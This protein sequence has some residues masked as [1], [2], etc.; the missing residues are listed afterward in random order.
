MLRCNFSGMCSLHYIFE[1]PSSTSS[2]C[3]PLTISR[4]E[5]I[6]ASPRL[7]RMLLPCPPPIFCQS[8]TTNLLPVLAQIDAVISLEKWY[9][10]RIPYNSDDINGSYSSAIQFVYP[11]YWNN[12]YDLFLE[13]IVCEYYSCEIPSLKW[14]CSAMAEVKDHY[15]DFR[16]VIYREREKIYR[17]NFYEILNLR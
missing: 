10:R 4:C 16:C 9:H 5:I 11:Q 17:E 6:R 15:L 7:L 14:E 13:L 2:Y 8:S 3:L 1:S 12:I